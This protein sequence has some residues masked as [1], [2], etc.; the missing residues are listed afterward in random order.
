MKGKFSIVLTVCAALFGSACANRTAATGGANPEVA[1]RTRFR[2]VLAA[3]ARA[4][5]E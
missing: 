3:V 1:A 2:A 5:L 4:T